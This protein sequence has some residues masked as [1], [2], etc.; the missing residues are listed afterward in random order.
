M[1]CIILNKLVFKINHLKIKTHTREIM[2]KSKKE[3]IPTARIVLLGDS[4]VGKTSLIHRYTEN[5][6]KSNISMTTSHFFLFLF[7]IYFRDRL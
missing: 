6:F 3:I 7:R 4:K 5:E 2:K 1:I